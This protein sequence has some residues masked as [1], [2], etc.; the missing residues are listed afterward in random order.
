MRINK[1]WKFSTEMN[2]IILLYCEKKKRKRYSK[3]LIATELFFSS[4]FLSFKFAGKVCSGLPNWLSGKESTYKQATLVCPLEK[5][6]ATHSSILVWEIP[7]TEEPGRLQ[8]IGS[9][10]RVRHDLLTKYQQQ[11]VF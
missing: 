6:M 10:S 9:Q 11:C 3:G 7:G 1:L 8:F 4:F 5:E 2:I